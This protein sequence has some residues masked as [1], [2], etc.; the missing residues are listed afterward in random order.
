L[1]RLRECRRDIRRVFEDVDVLLLPTMREPAPLLSET[2]SGAHHRP[3][4]NVSAFNRFGIPALTVPCGFARNGM[5]VGLQIVGPAFGE[6]TVLAVAH[7]YQEASGSI[8]KLDA[9]RNL[10]YP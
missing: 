2:I 9:K 10:T 1:K 3:P 8:Q 6:E 7:A 5:P 4:S